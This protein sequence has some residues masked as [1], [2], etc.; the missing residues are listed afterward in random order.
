MQQF[1]GSTKHTFQDIDDG[2]NCDLDATGSYDRKVFGTQFQRVPK[3]GKVNEKWASDWPKTNGRENLASPG[4]Y[5]VKYTCTNRYDLHTDAIRTIVI[6]SKD[7]MMR[8][9]IETKSSDICL[10]SFAYSQSQAQGL[11]YHCRI[12][13][14][15]E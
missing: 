5:R 12:A 10:G 14:C 1:V 3:H 7:G 11:R 8:H 4:T 6:D 9:V 2:A 15:I 13:Q